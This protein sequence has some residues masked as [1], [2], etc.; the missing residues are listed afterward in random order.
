M[1]YLQM[2]FIDSLINRLGPVDLVLF[3]LLLELANLNLNVMKGH[4]EFW[5]NHQCC[6]APYM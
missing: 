3:T 1:L 5:G 2:L 4:M 6:I